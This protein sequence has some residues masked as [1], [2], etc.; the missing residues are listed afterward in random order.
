MTQRATNQL[1]TVGLALIVGLAIAGCTSGGTVPSV[2]PGAASL[3]TPR[4]LSP[5]AT[6]SSAATEAASPTEVPPGRVLF[7]RHEA[8]GL[9][10]YYT[11]NTDGTDEQALFTHDGCACARWSPDGTRVWTMGETGHHTWSL[12]TM[13]PD[14]SERVVISPS[15][16]AL[17]LGPAMPSADGHWVAFDGWDDTNPTRNGLYLGSPG[18]ADLRLVTPLPKGTVHVDPLG[19]TPDGS[20]VLFMTERADKPHLEGDLY[21]V[22]SDGRGLRQLN[23]PGTT[24]NFEAMPASLSPDGRQAAFGVDDAV[25]IVDLDGGEARSITNR[26]GFVWAVSWSSTGEWI[27][28]T[29]SNGTTIVV[30]LVRPDGTDQRSISANDG[31][32]QAAAGMWSPD[33]KYLLVQYGRPQDQWDLW[34]MDLEGQYLGQVT[35]EPSS[36]G[37]YS[38]APGGR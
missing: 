23:P 16:K 18:L 34:I 22:N 37:T 32:L 31:S 38:W 2:T 30:A 9:E 19:V 8:D 4:G 10:H 5:T 33:G 17:N 36:Y 26:A 12:T 24:L 28:Y 13:L 29:R 1:A 25:F 21:V 11:I 15:I 6:A 3:A 14:G 27:T 35:H 7:D 20:R